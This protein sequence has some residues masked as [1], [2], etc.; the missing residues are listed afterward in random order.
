MFWI[1]SALLGLLNYTNVHCPIVAWRASLRSCG[2]SWD[3]TNVYWPIVAWRASPRSCG[4]SWGPPP[5]T[6]RCSPPSSWCSWSTCLYNKL[7]STY[8]VRCA[9][10]TGKCPVPT[11]KVRFPVPT[12]SMVYSTFTLWCAVPSYTVWCAVLTW[13]SVQYIQIHVNLSICAIQLLIYVHWNFYILPCTVYYNKN[14][15]RYKC[16]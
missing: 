3:Y 16:V 12:H 1:I 7:C 13:Y 5:S 14:A 10:Y 9:T 8:T 11:Y 2:G 15:L 4:G 6:P